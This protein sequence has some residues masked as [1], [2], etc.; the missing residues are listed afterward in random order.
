MLNCTFRIN[1]C[2]LS[3]SNSNL[4]AVV[5][6]WVSIAPWKFWIIFKSND[7]MFHSSNIYFFVR[8]LEIILGHLFWVDIYKYRH[9]TWCKKLQ[10]TYPIF[11]EYFFAFLLKLNN[12][13]VKTCSISFVSMCCPGQKLKTINISLLVYLYNLNQIHPNCLIF[14]ACTLNAEKIILD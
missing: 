8:Y 9:L 2:Y 13:F 14:R 6:S 3:F 1:V 5:Q 11:I 7:S 12:R 4:Y 10:Y